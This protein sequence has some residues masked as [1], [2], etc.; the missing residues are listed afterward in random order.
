MSTCI[1]EAVATSRDNREKAARNKQKQCQQTQVAD[2]TTSSGG[3]KSRYSN[4]VWHID[5]GYT[6]YMTTYSSLFFSLDKT[7][8]TK[9]K[10]DNGDRILAQEG[11][12][13]NPCSLLLYMSQLAKNDKNNEVAKVQQNRAA[14]QQNGEE[15]TQNLEQGIQE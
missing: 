13:T 9:I 12:D 2:A 10:I 11:S 8:R 14:M 7:C 6:H 3:G 1:L 15:S 5:S 4:G